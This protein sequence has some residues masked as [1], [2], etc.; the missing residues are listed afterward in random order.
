MTEYKICVLQIN[1]GCWLYEKTD[2][3]LLDI[4]AVGSLEKNRQK[5]SEKL[6][7]AKNAQRTRVK[8]IVGGGLFLKVKNCLIRKANSF[9][10][11]WI[12]CD[13]SS[14]WLLNKKI[15]ALI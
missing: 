15:I 8:Y 7:D 9:Q 10:T 2:K 3:E 1:L 4:F 12:C 6:K 5:L 14:Y 11:D 13:N